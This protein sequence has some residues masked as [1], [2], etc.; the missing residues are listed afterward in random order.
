MRNTDVNNQEPHGADDKNMLSDHDFVALMEAEHKAQPI[1]T[2]DVEKQAMWNAVEQRVSKKST[3]NLR[4][5]ASWLVAA[6]AALVAIPYL[7]LQLAPSEQILRTKG[8]VSQTPVVLT[9]Y[10]LQANGQTSILGNSVQSGDTVILKVGATESTRIA[11]ALSINQQPFSLRFVSEELAAGMEQL[12]VNGKKTY[13]Y[14][15][16]PTD[17]A[18][19]FCALSSD[20]DPGKFEDTTRL[21]Q[22]IKQLPAS[23]CTTLFVNAPA[24]Q[25]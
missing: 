21:S 4:P 17:H 12:L 10:L 19:T 22:A 2:N 8:A 15:V 14:A 16:E 11:L 20:E 13:G 3:R 24:V 18:L 1:T 25:P 5:W 6:A 7:L 9:A 23:A